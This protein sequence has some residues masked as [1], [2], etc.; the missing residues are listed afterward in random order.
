MKPNVVLEVTF[1]RASAKAVET[2][3]VS[4]SRV[5]VCVCAYAHAKELAKQVLRETTPT[6]HQR[7]ILGNGHTQLVPHE[8]TPGSRLVQ[9]EALLLCP[10][11]WTTISYGSPLCPG[12]VG[13]GAESYCL[14]F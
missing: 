11:P 4:I 8:K 5:C 7:I 12:Q 1:S 2:V 13:D 3:S 14:G 6:T 10:K 9:D